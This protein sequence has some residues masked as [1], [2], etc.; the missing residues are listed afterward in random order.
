MR[1]RVSRC[2]DVFRDD[3]VTVHLDTFDHRQRAYVFHFNPV[4]FQSDGISWYYAMQP[5]GKGRPLMGRARRRVE[6]H[7]T[8]MG[9]RYTLHAVRRSSL[10]RA[11]S[12]TETPGISEKGWA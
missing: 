12:I 10:R 6:N 8:G 3:Y 2:D 11:R 9:A 5:T 7:R 4:G 1:A